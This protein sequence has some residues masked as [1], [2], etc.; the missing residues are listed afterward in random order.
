MTVQPESAAHGDEEKHGLLCPAVVSRCDLSRADQPHMV[1]GENGAQQRQP[2]DRL[3]KVYVEPTNRCNLECRTCI[4]HG[5]E[6]PLGQM[7]EA[8]FARIMDGLRAYSPPPTVFF[9]G[10]GEPLA[11]QGIVGM[12]AQVKALGGPV[13][14]ITNGTLLTRDVS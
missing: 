3:A 9:G 4:R 14:L 7:N 6:E 10:F 5:W 2:G 1:I 12:V 11:H 8:T 13:E